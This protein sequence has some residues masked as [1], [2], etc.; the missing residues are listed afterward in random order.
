MRLSKPTNDERELLAVAKDL[1]AKLFTRRVAVRLA[2]I[3][4][5]NLEADRQQNELFDTS[6]NRRWYLNREMD[7]VRG[8][9]GWNA[10]FYGKGLT[11]REHYATKPNGLVL[12]TPC[13]SR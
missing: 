1:F 7:R 8:R 6:A 5:T 11:L 2:G 9:F 12:S 10:V 4:V 3:S 13:L